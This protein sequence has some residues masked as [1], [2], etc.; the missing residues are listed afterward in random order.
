MAC[1]GFY[2]ALARFKHGAVVRDAIPIISDRG[3]GVVA[4]DAQRGFSQLAFEVGSK[5]LLEGP[6]NRDRSLGHQQLLSLLSPVARNRSLGRA[7]R[8]GPSHDSQPF[9]GGPCGRKPTCFGTNPIAFGWPR[10]GAHPYIFD[11]ATSEVARG[12]LRLYQRSG[13]ALPEG[14]GSTPKAPQVPMPQPYSTRRHAD[15]WRLQRLC[16]VD[17]DQGCW[18]GH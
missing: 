8:C 4:V 2:R 13:R 16:P 5:V 7:W 1:T 17:H 14:W 18:P 12:E 3:P 10:V 15:F 9:L 6:D 11:F